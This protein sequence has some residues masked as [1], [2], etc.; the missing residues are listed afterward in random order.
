MNIGIIGA[1]AAGLTSA[2]L[3]NDELEVVVFEREDR[4]GGH[5]HTIKVKATTETGEI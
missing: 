3:L 1:G 5:A 2:W 4:L